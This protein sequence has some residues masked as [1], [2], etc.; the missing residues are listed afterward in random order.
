M[1]SRGDVFDLLPVYLLIS[2]FTITRVT[3]SVQ[4]EMKGH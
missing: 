1:V 4:A 3:G 2:S